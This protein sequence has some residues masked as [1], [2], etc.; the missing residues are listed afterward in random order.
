MT[1]GGSGGEEVVVVMRV[2]VAVDVVEEFFGVEDGGVVN[3]SFA[4]DGDGV[5]VEKQG[6][7]GE[8]KG[9][10]LTVKLFGLDGIGGVDDDVVGHRIGH[11][12]IE[13][14]EAEEVLLVG[15]VV[16]TVHCG[17]CVLDAL[18]EGIVHF[19]GAVIYSFSESI[20]FGIDK[21]QFFKSGRVG[22]KTGIKAT[23]PLRLGKQA[24]DY[25]DVALREAANPELALVTD[26][27]RHLGG[28]CGLVKIG[29][30]V[31]LQQLAQ[32]VNLGLGAGKEIFENSFRGI[33]GHSSKN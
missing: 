5:K 6:L 28:H 29:L 20:A 17:G 18:L 32:A 15:G 1:E 7:V 8:G 19:V 31:R 25:V 22:N 12:T 14:G 26:I 3:V 30:H 16:H 24:A 4:F 2:E 9:I 10:T 23:T 11:D 21:S 33:E 27:V 13:V